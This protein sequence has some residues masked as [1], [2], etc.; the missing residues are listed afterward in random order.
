MKALI[1]KMAKALV[2]IPEEVTVNELDGQKTVVFELRV[3]KSD[4]G[5]VVGK[6]GITAQAMRTIISSAG[7]KLGKRFLLEIID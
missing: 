2:D 5:K 7:T 4:V 3:A 6:R 1:E